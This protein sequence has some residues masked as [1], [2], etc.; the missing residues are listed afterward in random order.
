MR[1]SSETWDGGL[2]TAG[3]ADSGLEFGEIPLKADE[4]P[5]SATGPA[6]PPQRIQPI[7][8]RF[9]A[10]EQQEIILTFSAQEAKEVTVAGDFN[11]WSPDAAPLEKTGDGDWALRLMLR[12]GQ[13][14]YRFV[15]DGRWYEDPQA[16]GRAACPFGG[17]N[18]VLLVPLAV[19]TSIL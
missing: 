15:V 16:S 3:S 14:E 5:E 19:R 7:S 6:D 2:A 18:S 8:E 10:L 4:A 9:P 13:Y 12:S 11:G 17:F 1:N